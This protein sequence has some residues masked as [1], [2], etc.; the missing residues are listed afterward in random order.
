MD[1]QLLHAKFDRLDNGTYIFAGGGGEEGNDDTACDDGDTE[2]NEYINSVE[3][4]A[5]KSDSAE[6]NVS[7]YVNVDELRR[8]H[9]KRRNMDSVSRYQLTECHDVDREWNV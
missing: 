7:M 5:N 8:H 2:T 1:F 9:L 6:K 3:L 4:L